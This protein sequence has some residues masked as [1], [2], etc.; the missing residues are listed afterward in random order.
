MPLADLKE[1]RMAEKM[2]LRKSLVASEKTLADGEGRFEEFERGKDTLD[3]LM[4]SRGESDAKL[5]SSDALCYFFEHKVSEQA[6]YIS[7]KNESSSG[8]WQ[9][10]VG[11]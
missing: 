4:T 2:D 11:L 3:D 7:D 8:Y 1:S 6:N 10:V 5:K 9:R